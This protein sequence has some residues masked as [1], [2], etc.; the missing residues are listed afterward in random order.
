[1]LIKPYSKV[2]FSLILIFTK[3]RYNNIDVNKKSQK[4]CKI[5]SK[6]MLKSNIKQPKEV[7]SID[8]LKELDIN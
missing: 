4:E 3:I 2:G 8:K 1:M 5:E 7:A 6:R